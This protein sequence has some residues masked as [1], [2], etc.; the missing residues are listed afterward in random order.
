MVGDFNQLRPIHEHFAFQTSKKGLL[1]AFGNP[2]WEPFRL[3][4]LNEIMRQKDDLMFAESLSRMAIGA[5]TEADID[6]YKQ[7]CFTEANLPEDAAEAIRIMNTNREVDNYNNKKI[8]MLETNFPN[9]IK[10]ESKAI[11]KIVRGGGHTPAQQEAALVL[12]SKK[13]YQ[14]THNL[15]YMLNLVEGI[16]Y[17]VTNNI[18]VSDGLFNGATGVLKSIKML[19]NL[20]FIVYIKFDDSSIGKKARQ[21]HSTSPEDNIDPSWTPI[22]KRK[23]QFTCGDKGSITI[24]RHQFALVPAEA[25]T[26]HKAQGQS[27]EKV[28]VEWDKNLQRKT[29]YV[30]C[31]RATTLSG[32]FLLGKFQPPSPANP[33]D[34]CIQ[35]M[36]RMRREAKLIPIFEFLRNVPDEVLQIISHN[37]QSLKAHKSTIKKDDVYMQS[38]ILALSET[39]LK[40]TDKIEFDNFQETVRN[41]GEGST[42]GRGTIIFNKN[43][44]EVTQCNHF[45]HHSMSHHF[46][47]T[48]CEF[49]DLVLINVYISPG[50]PTVFFQSKFILFTSFH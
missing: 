21:V 1:A 18:D 47:A 17:M 13:K 37:V 26:I 8:K 5:L 32:L 29:L 4:E 35:E 12:A 16:R 19:G 38:S 30:C 39:W 25:I 28:V 3:F 41:G 24:L 2:N 10:H 34:E 44:L 40:I 46:E 9:N 49:N 48:S 36:N 42:R 50:A 23:E 14:D 15:P 45:E 11:D 33:N 20:P 31:S 43:N 6:M 27:Y 22:E 7:R